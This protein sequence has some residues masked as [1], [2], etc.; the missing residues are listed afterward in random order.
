MR[1]RVRQGWA[2]NPATAGKGEPLTSERTASTGLTRQHPNAV[3]GRARRG[4]SARFAERE[5]PRAPAPLADPTRA[6]SATSMLAGRHEHMFAWRPAR[7][8]RPSRQD[9]GRWRRQA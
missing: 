4:P 5:L 9:S 2:A 8:I 1:R 7:S 3:A 6:R